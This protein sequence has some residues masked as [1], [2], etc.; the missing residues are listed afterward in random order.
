MTIY[1][2]SG[3][4]YQLASEYTVELLRVEPDPKINAWTEWFGIYETDG[5]VGLWIK[6]GYAWDGPSGPAMDTKSAM[7]GSLIHDVLYQAIRLNLLPKD[8]RRGADEEYR[9]I[10]IE[11]GM[12]YIRAWAHFTALRSFGG[13]AANPSAERRMETAP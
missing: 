11:D 12:S 7:R 5:R 9:R 8:Q 2:R 1:Y 13:F 3:Y 6:D 10:C 4:R